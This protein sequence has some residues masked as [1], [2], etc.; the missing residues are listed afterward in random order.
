MKTANSSFDIALI[1]CGRISQAYLEAI[2][3]C[4]NVTLKAVMDSRKDAADAIAEAASCLAFNDIDSLLK[5]VKVDGAIVCTPPTFHKEISCNLLRNGISVLCEK[6]LAISVEDGMAMYKT[7]K[8]NQAILMMASKFRYV[9]DI[10]RAKSIIASD[11]L[12]KIQFYENR[13]CSRVNMSERWNIDPRVS[14]GGVLIDNGPHSLDIVRYLVGPIKKVYAHESGRDKDFPVEDTIT[15]SFVTEK[16]LMGT[17]YLSWSIQTKNE[18]YIDVVGTD[19]AIRVGWEKSLYQY[20][21]HPEWVSFGVGYQKVAAFKNQV[22]N[23]VETVRGIANPLITPRA[24]LASIQLISL[25][26]ESLKKGE[27][28]TVKEDI[29][30]GIE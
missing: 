5:N 11:M 20:N 19:G 8:E 22:K 25:A 17:I 2:K 7:A 21:G 16:N 10:I 27:W 3:Q 9:E 4:K 13:F 30:D 14:G 1:G 15:L 18:S 23:F 12:G 29:P 28:V 6:P 26:Y 24:G